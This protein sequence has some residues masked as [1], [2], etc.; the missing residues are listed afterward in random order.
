MLSKHLDPTKLHHAYVITSIPLPDVRTHIE[1]F[2]VDHMQIPFHGNPDVFVGEYTTI[3]IDDLSEVISMHQRVPIG[4][5]KV[6][7]L[8]ANGITMQAQNS[9]LKMIE[10][11]TANTHFFF[12]LPTSSLLLPTVLSRVHVI[13]LVHEKELPI[14]SRVKE[15][16][17]AIVPGRLEVIKGMLADLDKERITKEEVFQ[18]ISEVTKSCYEKDKTEGTLAAISRV[19]D[20]L[21]DPSASLKLLFEYLALRLPVLK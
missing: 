7:V 4:P 13:Q 5:K 6:L 10:E 3:G 15:F 17:A 20:Y 9:I 12:A 11:P 21:R 2:V 1:R 8:L 14:D 18:F 16:L 19:S